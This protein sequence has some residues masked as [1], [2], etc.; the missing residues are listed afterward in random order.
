M[1]AITIDDDN[2]VSRNWIQ[3]IYNC[4]KDNPTVAIVGGMGEAIFEKEPPEWFEKFQLS[5][6]VGPQASTDGILL[7][8]V[9]FLY[10]AGLTVRKEIWDLI[11]SNGFEFLLTGRKGK[12]IS[13]GE[14]S[15]MCLAVLLAGYDIYY[16]SKLTFKHF[17]P[18]SRLTKSYIK[19]LSGSF[20][21]AAVIN[22]I[23]ISSL[24]DYK[25]MSKWKIQNYFL[26]VIHSLYN[27]IKIWPRCCIDRIL[28]SGWTDSQN[29]FAYY[30]QNLLCKIQLINRYNF[31]VNTIVNA[32][33]HNLNKNLALLPIGLLGLIV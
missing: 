7:K 6:A 2:C 4:L 5:F 18:A 27:A 15:E 31:Y 21:R 1:K 8:S 19:R 13:S 25:K 23:Y 17:M 29:K 28:T 33:W 30:W 9:S 22:D 14:D 26:S 11:V 10:G 20:G 24:L 3:G 12:Q 32:K 16:N